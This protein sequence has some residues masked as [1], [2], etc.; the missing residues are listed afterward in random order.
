MHST[1]LILA[2]VLLVP[3]A[4]QTPNPAPAQNPPAAPTPAAAT[5]APAPAQPAYSYQPDGRRDPFVSL[6]GRG[7]DPKGARAAG[8][9]GMLINEISVKGIMK[10]RDGFISR[11]HL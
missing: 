9:P 3:V 11:F 10:S 7:T 1:L 5:A 2:A 8:V 4:A 6:L